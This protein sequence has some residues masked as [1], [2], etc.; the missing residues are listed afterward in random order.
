MTFPSLTSRLPAVRGS[1]IENAPL[2]PATW[3]RAGGPAQALFLPADEADLAVFLKNMPTDIPVT[4]LGAASNVIIR[5][6]G[7]PGVVVRLGKPFAAIAVDGVRVTVGAALLDKK[8]AEAAADAG[9]SGLEFYSGVP[10]TIGG[11]LRMNAGCYGRETK[12]ALVSAAAIDRSG[13][14]IVVSL[15]ELEYSY[16]HSKAP[17]DWI[18]VQATFEG[19][20]DDP[21]AIKARMADIAAK[22]EASQ[23]IREKT[24]GSTFANPDPPGTENQRRAWMLIDQAGCRGLRVGGAQMSEQHANFMINA[25]GATAAD[26][27]GLGE[28]VRR[29][30]RE[31]SGVELRWEIKRIG[32][33]IQEA[34]LISEG[35]RG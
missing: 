34:A 18:F 25:G 21:A 2:A 14:R 16:R 10:G 23:P 24:G 4:V 15:E 26:L 13:R 19:S 11:A 27:E 7:V 20:P 3:F 28:E 33:T 31:A 29:R 5:D 35:D 8:V 12:D 30:V 1:L 22:R 9:V 32:V 17:E 6:G